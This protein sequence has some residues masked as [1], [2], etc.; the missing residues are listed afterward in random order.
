MTHGVNGSVQS[1]VAYNTPEESYMRC[2]RDF[3]WK[4]EIVNWK[5]FNITDKDMEFVNSLVEQASIFYIF[6]RR[7]T[8][9]VTKGGRFEYSIVFRETLHPCALSSSCVIMD[10]MLFTYKNKSRASARGISGVVHF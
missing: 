7:N 2:L 1:D 9:V 10:C 6:Y 4:P 8:F 5:D 3:I